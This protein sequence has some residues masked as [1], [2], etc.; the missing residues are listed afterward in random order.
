MPLTFLPFNQCNIYEQTLKISV[1]ALVEICLNVGVLMEVIPD[2][3]D[4]LPPQQ[5]VPQ[6]G[7]HQQSS[8]I[9]EY[10]H[11]QQQQEKLNFAYYMLDETDD[12]VDEGIM[13]DRN[14][15]AD[16]VSAETAFMQGIFD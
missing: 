11:K 1:E 2:G 3:I 4:I 9:H 14:Y 10:R 15:N 8:S 5:H 7:L 13:L 16:D 12:F 6:L